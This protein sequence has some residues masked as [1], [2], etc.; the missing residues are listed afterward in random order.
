[1]HKIS[2]QREAK[3]DQYK[4]SESNRHWICEKQPDAQYKAGDS[5]KENTGKGLY[6]VFQ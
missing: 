6:Q 5:R 4:T 2:Q 1:M 3:D